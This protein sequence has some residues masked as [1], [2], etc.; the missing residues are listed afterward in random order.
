MN[1]P[2]PT[3]M[4]RRVDGSSPSVRLPGARGEAAAS[5]ASN[6]TEWYAFSDE[7]PIVATFEE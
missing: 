3:F 6:L 7:S 1:R 5:V 4:V 2:P